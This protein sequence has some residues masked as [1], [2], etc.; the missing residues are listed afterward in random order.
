L[1]LQVSRIE[2]PRELPVMAA[3]HCRT[4]C[5]SARHTQREGAARSV[6]VLAAG[7]TKQ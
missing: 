2:S 5:S 6:G 7:T 1:R 3:V 4:G